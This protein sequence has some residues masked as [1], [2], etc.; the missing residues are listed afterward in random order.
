MFN[1]RCVRTEVLVRTPRRMG[2]TVSVAMFVA[3]VL[4]N[5]PGIKICIFSTGQR[6]S[7]GLMSEIKKLL[8]KIPN[9][10]ERIVKETQEELRF[11]PCAVGNTAAEKNAAQ[12]SDNVS[13]LYSYPGGTTCQL[14]KQNTFKTGD[15]VRPPPPPPPSLQTSNDFE[16]WCQASCG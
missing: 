4:E 2:K 16:T 13:I 5:C 11:A 7:S 6:A 9:G 12:L 1:I 8:K 3:A 14:T 15:S 10:T